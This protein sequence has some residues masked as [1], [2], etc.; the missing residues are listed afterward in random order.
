MI[1]KFLT[2]FLSLL[3]RRLTNPYSGISSRQTSIR[4][5]RRA[6][7]SSRGS[8]RSWLLPIPNL[9][10]IVIQSMI[11]RRL[12]VCCT[13]TRNNLRVV[14]HLGVEVGICNK[15]IVVLEEKITKMEN[16]LCHCADQGKGKG[17]E[18]V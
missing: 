3:E 8:M 18:V 9:T 13:N 4:L 10:A 1:K 15:T 2:L 6:K 12:F 14:D 17:K 5:A 7:P 16:H 11:K